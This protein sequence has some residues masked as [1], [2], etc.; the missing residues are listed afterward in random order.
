MD[1]II[2][3]NPETGYTVCV[4]KD[5]SGGHKQTAHPVTVVGNCA[6]IWDG[7]TM[8]AEGQWRHHKAHGPQ[9][10]ASKIVCS[11]PTSPDGIRR[12]L[13]SGMIDGIGPVLAERLVK[14][15]GTQTLDIIERESA[16][17]ETV[18]GIGRKRRAQIKAAWNDQKAVRDI[19]IFLHT[20][21]IGTAQAN[22]IYRA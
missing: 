17:L 22:R 7:E 12:Y 13:G 10:H 5:A 20:H 1:H 4:L 11:A 3:R 15:F 16:R 6:A 19:M 21:G 9:F 2:F 8:E 18:E 14:K